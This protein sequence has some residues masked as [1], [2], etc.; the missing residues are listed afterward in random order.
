MRAGGVRGIA[1]AAATALITCLLYHATLLPGMD[2]GDSASFQTDAG[3]TLLTPRQGYPLYFALLWIAVKVAPGDAAA[4]ANLASA[5]CGALAAGGLTILAAG[6]SRSDLAGMFSG[7]LFAASYTFWSQS[8]TAEVYTLHIVCVAVTLIAFRAWADKPSPLRLGTAFG[9]YAI[10]FGNHLSM[11]LTAP[12]LVAFIASAHPRGWRGLFE[13]RTVAAA[14]A[15]A[16]AGAAQYAWNVAGMLSMPDVPAGLDLVRAFWFDV[17]KTD[18]R[19]SM[20]L[21]TPPVMLLDRVAMYWFD[22]RQQFG[23]AGIALAAAGS[24]ALA[25]ARRR[26]FLLV[27]AVFAA[28]WVFAFTYNVGDVHVFFLPSHLMVAAL[29]G[30]GIAA[31]ARWTSTRYGTRAA[32]VCCAAALAYAG[33]RG[34]DTFPAV[35]RSRDRRARHVFDELTR[36]LPSDRAVLAADFNWQLQNGLSYYGKYHKPD[37]QYF[38]AADRL[39]GFPLLVDANLDAG[40]RVYVSTDAR[41]R[42]HAAFGSLYSIDPDPALVVTGMAEIASALPAG[43][44]YVL[45]LLTP[46]RDRPVDRATVEEIMAALAGRDSPSIPLT[47]YTAVAGVKGTAPSWLR[48]STT[49]FRA[50]VAVGARDLTIRMDSWLASDTIRRADFGHVIDGRRHALGIDRGLS[51]VAWPSG[52]EPVVSYQSS[53]YALQPRFVVRAAAAN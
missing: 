52:R 39:I 29:A 21:G 23:L 46:Y 12:A 43:T 5:V 49:P 27:L 50:A 34:Y 4:A 8:V 16:L 14:L 45:C 38:R 32:A 7:L 3:T 11:I 22:V 28:N 10:G 9:V 37:L 36:D 53:L 15:A 48:S 35:D 41:R 25:R 24:M 51:F 44:P 33:W 17:T 47:G 1:A 26:D 6:L 18:W 42:V 40:R 2:L 19:E 13:A 31:A 20:V 30:C